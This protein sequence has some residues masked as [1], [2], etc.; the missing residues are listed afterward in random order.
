ML[1]SVFQTGPV[2]AADGG[3]GTGTPVLIQGHRGLIESGPP[4]PQSIGVYWKP[5]PGY[6][7]S[8]VGYKVP[9]AIVLQV[10]KKVSFVAPGI[11]ALPV[12]PGRIVTRQ[13]AI[14]AAERATRVRWRHAVAKL[15]T[16]TEIQAL[17]GR[18]QQIPAAPRLLTGSP[19]RPVWAVLLTGSRATPSVAVIDAASGQEEFRIGGHGLWFRA[20]TDRDPTRT[21]RCPGGSSALVP[22]GVPTRDEQAYMAYRPATAH[23]RTSVRLVL[24]TVPAV[25]KADSGLFGGCVQ[26]NCS[27]DQLVWVTITTVRANPGKT[28]ACLPGSVSVPAG[29]RPKQV[30]QY[31]SVEI[32]DSIGIGCGKVPDSLKALKDLAPP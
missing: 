16:W 2:T 3:R 4:S 32:P 29:Y 13:A 20:L 19:W 10:A 25:N 23:A 24:S 14:S 31:Y 11:V 1:G 15:S 27:L 18:R 30:K 8:V 17:A 22:F 28:V 21:G 7:V 12:T 5:R 6:L 26:Q 9:A